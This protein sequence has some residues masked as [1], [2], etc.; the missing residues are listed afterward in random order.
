MIEVEEVEEVEDE[1]DVRRGEWSIL[2]SY[3][4]RTFEMHSSKVITK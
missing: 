4:L 3:S 2:H 1:G